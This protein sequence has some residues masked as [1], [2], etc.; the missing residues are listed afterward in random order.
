MRSKRRGGGEG[1]GWSASEA[2]ES[3]LCLRREIWLIRRFKPLTIRFTPLVSCGSGL[4]GGLVAGLA[5]AGLDGREGV[6][7]N[8][9]WKDGMLLFLRVTSVGREALRGGRTD[10]RHFIYGEVEHAPLA[11]VRR[12]GPIGSDLECGPRLPSATLVATFRLRKSTPSTTCFSSTPLP[13]VNTCITRA[14]SLLN[15][16][17]SSKIR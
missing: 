7:G 10:D 14:H 11:P 9:V 15:A 4:D 3:R 5:A 16:P 17:V 8:L 13:A 6:E 2:E 12:G 1:R